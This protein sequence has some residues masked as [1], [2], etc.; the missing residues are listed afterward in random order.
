MKF[1]LW[2]DADACPRPVK[3]VVFKASQRLKLEVC[4]VADRLVGRPPSPLVST[5]RVP[6][7]MDQADKYIADKVDADDIVVTADI[8]LAAAVVEKGAI[9]LN[10]RGEQYD[11]ETVGERLSIRDFMA[12][13]R[14]T[15]VETGGPAPF[16][17]KDK[18]RFAAALD[19][20]LTARQKTHT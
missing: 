19:R 5:V 9:A 3:D 6:K 7:G 8:P 11:P 17:P 15:G 14:E 13:L 2:I 12:Q 16:G 10:P 1:K 18:Q 4:L 20:L